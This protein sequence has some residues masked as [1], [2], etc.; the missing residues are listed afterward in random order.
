[1][2]SKKQDGIVEIVVL[3]SFR[4]KYGVEAFKCASVIKLRAIKWTAPD[5]TKSVLVTNLLN[6]KR[7]TRTKVIALYFKRWSV[8]TIYVDE[9]VSLNIERFHSEVLIA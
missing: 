8:D 4:G 2:K 3:N 1:M 9:K 6:T 5:G 7:F